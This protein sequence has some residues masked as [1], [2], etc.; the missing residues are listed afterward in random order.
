MK[1]GRRA[2]FWIRFFVVAWVLGLCGLSLLALLVWIRLP[3]KT[4]IKGCIETKMYQVK[5][6]PGGKNYVPLPKISR[7]LQR[8]IIASEDSLFYQHEGFDWESIQKNAIENWKKGRYKRGGSTITQQLAKNMFLTKEKTLLRKAL[9]AVITYQIEKTLTKNEILE[10]YLNVIEF[11]KNIY[12]IN[13]AS[14]FYFK[15]KPS[16]LNIPESAFLAMILPNPIKN[17]RSFFTKKLSSFAKSRISRIID[18][19]YQ[20]QRIS[21]DEFDEAML[22]YDNFFG[23]PPTK[24]EMLESDQEPIQESD[25]DLSEDSEPEVTVDSGQELEESN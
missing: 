6:C 18:D 9:E 22:D 21:E 1:L 17:S 20:T 7:F 24:Q 4:E 16:Q 2:I 13:A 14:E 10:R 23:A 8:S 5:L 11:G 3:S 25:Q 15:K 19:L 12:G